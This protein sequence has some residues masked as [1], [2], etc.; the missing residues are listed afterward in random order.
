MWAG[1]QQLTA[2]LLAK[3]SYRMGEILANDLFDSIDLQR[4]LDYSLALY[5]MTYVKTARIGDSGLAWLRR[6]I[7]R[8]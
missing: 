6:D 8:A 5:C 2:R 3:I 1:T 7:R 4:W